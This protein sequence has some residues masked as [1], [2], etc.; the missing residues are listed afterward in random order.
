MNSP[1]MTVAFFRDSENS[2]NG[3]SPAEPFLERIFADTDD[4]ADVVVSHA[5]RALELNPLRN[6]CDI[7]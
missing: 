7:P 5:E 4:Q 6:V 3:Y 2:E 1:W